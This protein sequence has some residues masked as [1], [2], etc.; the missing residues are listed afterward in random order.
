RS[1][2]WRFRRG[3]RGSR[4]STGQNLLDDRA[5]G[6]RAAGRRVDETLLVAPPKK[7]L[8]PARQGEV[9]NFS[10]TRTHLI[11]REGVRCQRFEAAARREEGEYPWWIFDRRATP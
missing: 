5:R 2:A 4:G 6:E 10:R 7:S 8:S 11:N 9:F 1:D 3:D